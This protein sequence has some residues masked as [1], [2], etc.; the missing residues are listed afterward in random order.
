M[1]QD[2]DDNDERTGGDL[3]RGQPDGLSSNSKS[4]IGLYSTLGCSYCTLVMIIIRSK[5]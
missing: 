5:S 1:L 4:T 3:L 2:R